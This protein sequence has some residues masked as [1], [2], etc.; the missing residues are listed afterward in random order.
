MITQQLANQLKDAVDK[1]AEDC[2]LNMPPGMVFGTDKPQK[3]HIGALRYVA[4]RKK[5]KASIQAN[6]LRLATDLSSDAKKAYE[7]VSNYWLES[8]RNGESITDFSASQNRGDKIQDRIGRLLAVYGG[9]ETDLQDH[10]KVTP[11]RFE[12]HKKYQIR[13]PATDDVRPMGERTLKYD[14]KVRRAC[15]FLIYDSISIGL[16]IHYIVDEITSSSVA[17]RVM[18]SV[19]ANNEKV[20]ICTTEIREIFRHWHSL[21][22]HVIW[23]R[24]FRKCLPLWASDGPAQKVWAEYAVALLEKLRA[25]GQVLDATPKTLTDALAAGQYPKLIQ[26]YHRQNDSLLRQAFV[27]N[28]T[29]H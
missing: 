16:K 6:Q 3:E 18:F 25:S 21:S 12:A 22:A 1:N 4:Q 2:F 26:Y 29:A 7:Y 24:Q 20:P 9:Q 14:M 10:S 17:E 19:G 27:N 5:A 11:G 23:F 15:K 28:V 13:D 8:I